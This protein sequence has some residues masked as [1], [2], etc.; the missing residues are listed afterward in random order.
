M[1]EIISDTGSAEAAAQS[2]RHAAR[3]AEMRACVPLGAAG[4]TA[5]VQ[6]YCDDAYMRIRECV[7]QLS[8]HCESYASSISTAGTDFDLTD[9]AS[10]TAWR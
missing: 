4:T 10:A 9:K 5:N 7:N 1:S 2:L 8:W 6:Y 3:A